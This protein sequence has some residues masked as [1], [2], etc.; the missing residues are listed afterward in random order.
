MRL[1]ILDLTLSRRT[2]RPLSDSS[3]RESCKILKIMGSGSGEPKTLLAKVLRWGKISAGLAAIVTPWL[4][5]FDLQGD[6]DKQETNT[7]AVV[8]AHGVKLSELNNI[9]QKFVPWASNYDQWRREVDKDADAVAK[10][11]RELRDRVI[12]LEAFVAATNPRFDP[13]SPPA[14]DSEEPAPPPPSERRIEQRVLNVRPPEAPVIR[15]VDKAR[16]YNDVRK[17][18]QCRPND[19]H[20]GADALE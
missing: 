6:V 3:Q 1:S 2:Q 7:E 4:F 19:P 11:N 5:I 18:R 20:C 9:A 14:A 10:E 8:E 15:D 17:E 16:Q 12:R 13:L